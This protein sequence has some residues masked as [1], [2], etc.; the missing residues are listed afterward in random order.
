LTPR[1]AVELQRRLASEEQPVLEPERV[2]YIAGVDVAYDKAADESVAVICVLSYPELNLVE[3]V[4]ERRRIPFPYVPGLLS[5]REIPPILA[6]FERLETPVDMVFVD[7][8]GRAHPRRLG[9]AAHLGLWLELP[10]VGVG[11]SLLCG[12]FSEPGMNRGDSSPLRDK[13]EI[14]GTVLRTRTGVRPIFVSQGFGL[15]L[16]ACTEWTLR[17]TPRY[18]LPEPIRLADFWAGRLKDSSPNLR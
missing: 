18:R 8:H 10:A 4:S 5:F 1:E 16:K 13:D 14:I 3:T 12:E 6:A 15:S 9:I 2:E 7:G 11:K 17:V